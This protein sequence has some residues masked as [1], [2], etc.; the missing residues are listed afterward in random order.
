MVDILNALEVATYAATG[1]LIAIAIKI[2]LALLVHARIQ[3]IIPLLRYRS[4]LQRSIRPVSH[5]VTLPSRQTSLLCNPL[6]SLP[7]SQR[8]SLLV[9]RRSN[10]PY[11]LHRNP[12]YSLPPTHLFNHRCN[13]AVIHRL[14]L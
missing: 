9:S 11:N 5:Q 3:R 12:Q 7:D 8:R 1:I 6:G 4:L 2:A 13:R 10:L 14:S